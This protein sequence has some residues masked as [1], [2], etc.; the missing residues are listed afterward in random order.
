[1]YKFYD[2][3]YVKSNIENVYLKIN[4]YTSSIKILFIWRY[5]EFVSSYNLIKKVIFWGKKDYWFTASSVNEKNI[6]K[7]FK[8]NNSYFNTFLKKLYI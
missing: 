8:D 3:N 5:E 7:E 4:N 1:M 6:Y 2:F